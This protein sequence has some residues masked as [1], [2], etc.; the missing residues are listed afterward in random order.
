MSTRLNFTPCRGSSCTKR[1]DQGDLDLAAA[2]ATPFSRYL[3]GEWDYGEPIH[4]Y[5][6]KIAV[7]IANPEGLQEQ[8]LAEI[9]AADEW[10]ALGQALAGLPVELIRVPEPCTLEAIE[11]TLRA[12]AHIL[13]LIAHGEYDPTSD[14]AMVWLAGPNNQP[15]LTSDQNLA[16]SLQRALR[17]DGNDPL[18]SRLPFH[19]P[20]GHTQPRATRSAVSHLSWCKPACPRCSPCKILCRSRPPGLSARSSTVNS[21][22]TAR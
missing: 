5:P 9:V 17:H 11:A 18:T 16:D 13:H 7:A 14:R 1:A 10:Q 22:S 6:L 21:C 20:V 15:L 8:G 3:E 2:D 12:G 19:L 4:T